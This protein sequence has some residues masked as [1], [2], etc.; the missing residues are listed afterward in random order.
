MSVD[1]NVGVLIYPIE[2]RPSVVENR[3]R[4]DKYPAD[5]NPITVETS[6]G[7]ERYPKVPKPRVV[8]VKLVEVTS[9]EPPPDMTGN[10]LIYKMLLDKVREP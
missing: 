4:L 2:P 5:P 7:E 8:D 3:E 9:P 6:C 10:P 1:I